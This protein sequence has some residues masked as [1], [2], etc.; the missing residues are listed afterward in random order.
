MPPNAPYGMA[1]PPMPH[2][3]MNAHP[4]HPGA[5]GDLRNNNNPMM[6]L[7]PGRPMPMPPYP[8]SFG[9][10]NPFNPMGPPPAMPPHMSLSAPPLMPT[11]LPTG[12]PMGMNQGPPP[13]P[14]SS[15][16]VPP[17]IAAPPQMEAAPPTGSND[18]PPQV[19]STMMV[20]LTTGKP[21]DKKSN[22]S[23]HKSPDGRIYYYNN[24]TKQSS[25]EKPDELKTQAELL[26]SQC[27][28]KEYKSDTGRVYFHNIQSKESRWT[29]PKEL[30]DL[31]NA[32]IESREREAAEKQKEI[33]KNIAE[34]TQHPVS[35]NGNVTKANDNLASIQ[36]P[37]HEVNLEMPEVDEK[38]EEEKVVIPK[39]IVY[40]DKK[41]AL[42]AFKDLLREKDVPGN[43]SWEQALKLIIN[44]PRY[45]TLKKLNEKK[46][47]FNA[48]KT[49][50]LKE[51]R[52]EMRLKA[53]KAKEDLELFLQSHKEM[54]S[55]IR[56]RRADQLFCDNDLWK[57]VPERDRKE[58]YEDV[59]FFLIKKEKEEAKTLRKRNMQVL[60]DVLDSM[61]SITYLTTWHD[62][63]QL[64]LENPTFQEDP[65]LLKMDKVDAL[66]VFED[67]IRQLEMEE[68]EEKE[69]EKKRIRRQQ[70]RNREAFLVFLDELHELGK[71]TSMSLWVELYPTISAD[72]RFSHMLGQ[73]GSTPLDL[74]KFYVEELKSRFYDE[75]K[76]IKE[77]LK[78]RVFDVEA[79]TTYEEFATIISMDKRSMSLD[80]GNVKLTFNSLLEKA[81]A[82]EKERQKEETR[83]QRRLE[84]AF[85][86][87]LKNAIPPVDS[88]VQWDEVRTRLDNEAAFESITLESERVRLF[89]EYQQTL[90]ESCS[91]H[92]SKSKKHNKKNKK[93]KKKSRS[94][95]PSESEDEH[96][97]HKI[98]K[99]KRAKSAS[100]SR[101][102]S[103]SR[104]SDVKSAKSDEED[105][106]VSKRH[107]KKKKK[108]QSSR[109]P[110]SPSEAEV[111]V[112]SHKK[113]TVSTRS[114]SR[115]R[116]RSHSRSRRS[117]VREDGE[118]KEKEWQSSESELSENE[119][120][121]R[122]RDILKQLEIHNM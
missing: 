1:P 29:I 5:L 36:L 58:L 12:P 109:S 18:D 93:T 86:S 21:S 77:I 26:L 27:P 68:E 118:V 66:I 94:A 115:S 73:P 90:E 116:S 120:E 17:N 34:G 10:P 48:Y 14:V 13:N 81:E 72:T 7:P 71:L 15:I 111:E 74:F 46:Q 44:D 65:E 20:P 89:K 32:M 53:K 108:K 6:N 78:S 100:R 95:S 113:P 67:H 35:S 37:G 106:Q 16:A 101:S 43:A 42:E 57:I 25:W 75:K 62:A 30:E 4:H 40:K 117:D 19:P 38:E 97:K 33:D 45:G 2:N 114:R 23:E 61:T 51:D 64:L 107:K 99:K 63:Q 56:Y 52:E 105:D 85:K 87:M 70:R 104:D 39:P 49:Q 82:R 60:S 121:K 69:R 41:E 3:Y 91:H 31:K 76:I 80:A 92:H 28:W 96:N 110:S 47:A 59:I 103:A 112:H 22:W 24:V 102:R 122:K 119:L 98:K 9:M 55:T 8:P 84:N 83:K 79:N 54:N 50:R 11:P 88:S